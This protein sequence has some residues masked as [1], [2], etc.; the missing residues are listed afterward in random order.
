MRCA[1]S[2][3]LAS[4]LVLFA[5]AAT[6]SAAQLA[7]ASSQPLA[8]A[9]WIAAE[10]DSSAAA[11]LAPLPL[12]RDEFFLSKKISSATLY[13]SGLGQFEA[14]INSRNVTDTVLN[15]AWS[16][17]HKHIF[18]C[19]YDV[20]PLLHPGINAIGVMLGNGMYNVPITPGRYQKFHGSFGHPKLILQLEVK[21]SDGS[22]QSIVSNGAWK[23]APG[24][25][26]FTSIYGG[27]DYDARL[28]QTGWDLPG[29]N[30]K[31]WSSVAIVTGPGGILV[32]ETIPPIRLFNRYDPVKISHPKP[33][34]TVYDLGENSS[35]WPEIAV[36]GPRGSRVK[37]IAG[38][39]LDSRG[40]VT[41]R[42]AHAS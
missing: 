25:I 28:Q 37:L 27:E 7:A 3:L 42:S 23:T 36:H 15:P 6:S 39:L 5:S 16:D 17:Y 24:P 38:E 40:F 9:Q 4:I 34:L 21:F 26:T 22:S 19:T 33:G 12:F 32:P 8:R 29:F 30:A 31:H 18:Y 13:L 11:N 14:H 20:T 1:P 10:S 41:Q 2:W 35:G